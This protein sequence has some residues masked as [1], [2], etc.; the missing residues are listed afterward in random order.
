MLG[1]LSGCATKTTSSAGNKQ[2]KE[3]TVVLDWYPNA[4]HSFLYAAIEKGYFKEEGINVKIQFPANPT[5]PL[6]LTAAGKATVGLYYQ[7][8]VVI[9]RANEGVPVT[10]IGAVV[11]SPLNHVVSLEAAGIKSPKDLEGK[12]VGSSGTPL[13]EEYVKAMVKQDGGDPS[14]VKIVDVGF[15][16]VAALIT[17]KVDAVTGAY[18]NHEV[19]VLRHEGYPPAYFDPAK[20][21]VPNYYELVFVTGDSTLKKDKKTLQAFLRGAQ[22]G[23][24]FM[25]QNPD[26]A[27][28]ILLAH[29]EKENFP[30]IPEVEKESMNILLGKMESPQEAFLSQTSASWEEQ[31]KWLKDKGMA[32]QMV[33]AD[34]LF[35][36]I[37]K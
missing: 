9:A 15:D 19:P 12:T 29:Q 28:K 4:V 24:E 3:V 35:H 36:D 2:E 31:N 30:L 6:T 17:K 33:P 7:P 5:D 23:Y 34:E 26:E 16:L 21:G 37:L 14:K 10:S 20:Y 8:D 11:R 18:I 27:L 25:K 1:I 13:S 22:K 32:K